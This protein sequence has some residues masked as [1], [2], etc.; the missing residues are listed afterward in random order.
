MLE[1]EIKSQQAF[2]LA[3]AGLAYE[4][5][6]LQ[7]DDDWSD[8]TG[9]SKNLG[10]GSFTITYIGETTTDTAT[11]KSV[12]TVGGITRA[13]QQDFEGGGGGLA[14]FDNALYTEGSILVAGSAEGDIYGPSS[15]GD[16]IEDDE[17]VVFHEEPDDKNPDADVP[18]PDWDYWESNADDGNVIT[19]TGTYTFSSGTYGTEEEGVLYYIEKDVAFGSDVTFYGTIVTEGSVTISGHD[20]VTITATPPTNPAIISLGP[21]LFTGTSGLV[22]N[23]FVICL[24][25]VLLTGNT[26]VEVNG[27]IIAE[28]EIK[29]TGNLDVAITF[30]AAYSPDG[31]GFT[32][33]EPGGE[34]LGRSNW[35]EVF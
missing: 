29:M 9:G 35:Q 12:G 11:V 19:G 3:T 4:A 14:A 26:G 18:E 8:N 2:D 21:V 23:G 22:I 1:D 32:G 33:G 34:G 7:N 28:T 27:G 6:Q 31:S 24:S 10:R 5:E 30:D 13:V 20:N 16:V 15:A 25:D 17:D